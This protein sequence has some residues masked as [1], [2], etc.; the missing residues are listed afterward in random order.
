MI[1]YEYEL[2]IKNKG[3]ARR[4]FEVNEREKTYKCIK[5]IDGN[6]E[7]WG[8]KS[9]NYHYLSVLSKDLVDTGEIVK[10]YDKLLYY[11]TKDDVQTVRRLF[12][13]YINQHI[14]PSHEERI[15]KEQKKLEDAKQCCNDILAR[16]TA[17]S[18]EI[19]D[20]ER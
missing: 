19:E 15:V 2:S 14:I 20:M 13:D 8:S 18:R 6:A 16:Y 9:F 11:S 4:E 10:D 5:R 7:Y 17:D 3:I 1:L 12:I